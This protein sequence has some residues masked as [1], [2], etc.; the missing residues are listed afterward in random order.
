MKGPVGVHPSLYSSLLAGAATAPCPGR[1]GATA[2]RACIR[3]CSPSSNALCGRQYCLSQR[4]CSTVRWNRAR[5][6]VVNLLDRRK[7]AAPTGR[8]DLRRNYRADYPGARPCSA[9]CTWYVHWHEKPLSS[10]YAAASWRR[11]LRSM[12]CVAVGGKAGIVL[13]SPEH[14]AWTA[15]LALFALPITMANTIGRL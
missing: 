5:T 4:D 6:G 13:A 15:P 10:P 12:K 1:E 14:A 9:P 3:A 11:L 2:R 8:R 7:P